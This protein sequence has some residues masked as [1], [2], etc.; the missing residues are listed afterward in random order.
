MKRVVG[1]MC[2]LIF[3]GM[4]LTA[5]HGKQTRE[6]WIAAD[7]I[8]WDHAP[9][10]TAGD[11]NPMTGKPYTPEQEVFVADFIGS[12]YKKSVYR[13][14]AE[15]FSAVK[16]GP[17]HLGL[18]GPVIRA[19]VGDTIVI[20]FRNHTTQPASAHPHG[21]FYTKANEGAPYADGTS[22]KAGDIVL[23][24]RQHTYVWGVPRRAGPGPNDPVRLCGCI[25]ATLTNRGTPMPAWSDPSL[26]RRKGRPS[27]MVL[28]EESTA[29][30]FRSL[31]CWMRMPVCT[32]RPT[33]QALTPM[34]KTFKKVT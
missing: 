12:I 28:H 34:T 14:Y 8:A 33:I 30:S 7:E 5:A 21:V 6:Y 16:S 13:E 4:T 19:E 32:L 2:T 11:D 29:N 10:Y 9:S 17:A 24:G 18:L 15:G 22:D 23:P 26:L 3:L 27:E 1:F 31:P 25:M 20:H